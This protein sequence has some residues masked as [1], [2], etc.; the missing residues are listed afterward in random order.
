MKKVLFLLPLLLLLTG[1]GSNKV[2]CSAKI[3]EEGKQYQANIIG[4]LKDDKVVSGKMELIFND[5]EEAEQYCNLIKAF[6]GM[7]SEE[8]KID[9]KCDGKKMTVDSLDFDSDSEEEKLTG[10]TKDDFI[11]AVKDQYPDATCK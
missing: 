11:K 9:V 3:E 2:T 4:N 1:C 7:A 10:R 8:E 6:M 5:K